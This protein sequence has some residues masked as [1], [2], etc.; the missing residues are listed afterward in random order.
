MFSVR[1]S[2]LWKLCTSPLA[3]KQPWSAEFEG[4]LQDMP[5]L[6]GFLGSWKGTNLGRGQ[7]ALST[8][9]WCC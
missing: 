9:L 2:P 1:G 8:V 7:E 5:I 3:L 4:L 6:L